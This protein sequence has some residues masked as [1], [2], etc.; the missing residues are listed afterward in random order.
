MRTILIPVL[1]ATLLGG[2]AGIEPLPIRQEI[3]DRQVS[4]KSYE[5]GRPFDVVVGND[6]IRVKDYRETET[7]LD[8][9]EVTSDFT[10][11]GPF[12]TRQFRTGQALSLA[13]Q[14]DY[15]GVRYT[16]AKTGGGFGILFDADGAV[17]HKI[18]SNIDSPRGV[19]PLFVIH[20]Y[21]VAPAGPHLKRA[22]K[23]NAGTAGGPQD[24]AIVFSGVTA[25]AIRMSYKEFTP[26]DETRPSFTQELTYPRASKQLH[27]RDLTIMI[28]EADGDHLRCV[29]LSD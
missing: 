22:V 7:A 10:I 14:V 19:P 23:K 17:F 2:C 9:A 27:F 1:T 28:E 26:G 4:E 21:D 24:F 3:S 13:G 25:D 18:V 29:V 12:F 8:K 20:S 6:V 15:E 11:D 5:I 16:V